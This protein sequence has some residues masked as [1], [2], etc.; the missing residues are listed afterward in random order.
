M[1]PVKRSRV[2][3][4]TFGA[5]TN[6]EIGLPSTIMKMIGKGNGVNSVFFGGKVMYL[7]YSRQEGGKF[8]AVERI[9]SQGTRNEGLQ[10]DSHWL[11]QKLSFGNPGIP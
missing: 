6:A 2:S 3:E 11:E 8:G 10:Q 9:N 1:E 7:R 5:G 4:L